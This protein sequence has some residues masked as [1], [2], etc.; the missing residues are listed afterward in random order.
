MVYH[1]AYWEH[2]SQIIWIDLPKRRLQGFDNYWIAFPQYGMWQ[3]DEN[4][5]TMYDGLAAVAFEDRGDHE[6]EI[7]PTNLPDH[8]DTWRGFMLSDDQARFVGL[9]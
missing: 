9:I 8:A 3:D 1:I 7:D 5:G 4:M 6:I 2:P